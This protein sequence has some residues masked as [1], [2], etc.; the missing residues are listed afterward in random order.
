MTK[1]WQVL[2]VAS[3]QSSICCVYHNGCLTVY[4][5]RSA[6]NTCNINVCEV[7]Q[8]VVWAIGLYQLT[9]YNGSFHEIGLCPHRTVLSYW[10]TVFRHRHGVSHLTPMN[11]I[12]ACHSDWWVNVEAPH[13]P[14]WVCWVCCTFEVS[15]SLCLQ[16]SR[17]RLQP[18]SV[19]QTQAEMG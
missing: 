4:C 3:P 9:L 2:H 17:W 13:L 16:T 1:E 18:A 11:G 5:H 10:N 8:D 15:L 14:C 12:Y 19:A 6:T 7:L